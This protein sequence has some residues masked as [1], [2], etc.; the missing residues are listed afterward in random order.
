MNASQLAYSLRV[1]FLIYP[2]FTSWKSEYMELASFSCREL[3]FKKD[4]KDLFIYLEY[5]KLKTL[6][7]QRYL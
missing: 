7:K 6:S 5:M 1:Y 3:H 4:V 2:V